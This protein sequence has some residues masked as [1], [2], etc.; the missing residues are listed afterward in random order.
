MS[1]TKQAMALLKTLTTHMLCVDLRMQRSRTT[2]ILEHHHTYFTRAL[3]FFLIFILFYFILLFI[4]YL[5]PPSS[6]HWLL[7]PIL[8]FPTS[9]ALHIHLV[10]IRN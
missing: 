9:I 4:R 2:L 1:E 7:F 8:H 3:Y 6:L 10:D 5:Q